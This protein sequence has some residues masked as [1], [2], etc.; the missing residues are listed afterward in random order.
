MYEGCSHMQAIY[1]YMY[2]GRLFTYAGYSCVSVCMYVGDFNFVE[3]SRHG[4]VVCILLIA[5]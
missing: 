5:Q 3:L 1:M 4:L 2:V